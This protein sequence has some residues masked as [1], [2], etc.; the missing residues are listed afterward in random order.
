MLFVALT[1]ILPLLCPIRLS[2][3]VVL[4]RVYVYVVILFVLADDG[5]AVVLHLGLLGLRLALQGLLPDLDALAA[6]EA[7]RLDDV[8][9]L[10]LHT[11]RH[12][13]VDE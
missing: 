6:Q 12:L 4:V 1:K 5:L 2:V 11:V 10:V 3:I 9:V 8:R 7:Q 13:A